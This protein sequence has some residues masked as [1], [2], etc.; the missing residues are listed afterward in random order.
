MVDDDAMITPMPP[1]RCIC[2][3]SQPE[4]IGGPRLSQSDA[5]PGQPYGA[6]TFYSYGQY[7]STVFDPQDDSQIRINVCDAC[8]VAKSEVVWHARYVRQ[9]ELTVFSRPWG[10]ATKQGADH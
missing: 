3:D 9:P 5:E 4:D 1:L 8:L 2:C 10:D 7:G 6:T